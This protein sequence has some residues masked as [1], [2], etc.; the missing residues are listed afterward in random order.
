[1]EEIMTS[2][3]PAKTIT[4]IATG[5]DA[6]ITLICDRSQTL[7]AELVNRVIAR[8]QCHYAGRRPKAPTR[9]PTD[10]DL[11]SYLL[12]LYQRQG[13]V[14]L[15]SYERLTPRLEQDVRNIGTTRF[16]TI[17]GLV[18]H[19]EYLSFGIRLHDVSVIGNDGFHEQVGQ[20]RSFT[21]LAP[22]GDWHA[23]PGKL[24]WRERADEAVFNRHHRLSLGDIKTLVHH[25]RRESV[26]GAPYLVA[27]CLLIR[28]DDE[29]KHFRR[30][31]SGTSV[32]GIR[33]YHAVGSELVPCFTMGV[34]GFTLVGTYSL[35]LCTHAYLAQLYAWRELV[36][37]LTRIDE[38]AFFRHGLTTKYTAPWVRDLFWQSA[39]EGRARLH[40]HPN[41]WLSYHVRFVSRQ[42]IAVAVP[43]VA[44]A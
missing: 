35:D 18:S 23:E 1:L 28:L 6:D 16:G 7:T 25:N 14:S 15:S 43:L 12:A 26:M 30:H 2:Y 3:R 31:T 13:V 20:A 17:T 19:R 44:Y 37:W 29:I 22:T 11:A 24:A 21:L 10:M 32:P 8:S 36:Q 33:R 38:Y 41:L 4:A 40:L 34:H 9:T 42:A 5:T 39:G 27:K